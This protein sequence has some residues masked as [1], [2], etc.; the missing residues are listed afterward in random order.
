MD[1]GDD[2]KM[3]FFPE[4]TI[5]IIRLSGRKG[6]AQTCF[7]RRKFLLGRSQTTRVLNA[8][9]LLLS[10]KEIIHGPFV[11]TSRPALCQ[12]HAFVYA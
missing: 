3:R 1:Q 7:C 2:A 10:K 6:Q 11:L 8:S 9:P 12:Q 4:K 5:A